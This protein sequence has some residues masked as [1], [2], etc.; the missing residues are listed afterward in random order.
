MSLPI[1]LSRTNVKIINIFISPKL[2]KVKTNLD[3]LKVSGPDCI[4]V[5]VLRKCESEL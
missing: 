1:F 5:I 2:V 4:P 3:S